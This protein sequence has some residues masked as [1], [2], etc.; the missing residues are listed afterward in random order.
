LSPGGKFPR[1][2]IAV[3]AVL[4][5]LLIADLLTVQIAKKSLLVANSLDFAMVLWA[6]CC[7]FYVAQRSTGY[8]RQ[9]WTLLGI[10]LALETLAQ[11]ISTYYQSFVPGS[12]HALWP[13]DVL[14][15][16]WVAPVFMMF[17]PPP[18]GKGEGVDWL[19]ALDFAQI[20]IVAGTAYLYFFYVPSRWQTN[21]ASL[22][23]QILIL[24]IARDLILSAG[25]LLRS[26]TSLSPW[27]KLFSLGMAAVF[28]AAGA[29]DGDYLFTLGLT[30][31]RA[32]WGDALWMVPYFLVIVLAA[33]WKQS[34][35]VTRPASTAR[36][37]DYVVTQ[38]L[39]VVIP[40][41]VIFM[42]RAIAREQFLVAW[43]AITAS[44]LCS[45]LRL[46]LTNEKQRQIS[47]ELLETEHALRASERILA[48]AF[49][50]SPDGYSITVFPGGP[51]LD[52]N[53][54]F[55]RLTGY[56][57]GEVINKTPQD[58]SLWL[59]PL[60]RAEVLAQLIEK[61]EIREEEFEFRTKNGR[62]RTGQM[63][64]TLVDLD[65]RR[66]A[67]VAVR[68]V[69]ERKEAESLLRASEERFRSLVENLHVGIVSYDSSARIQF[70]NQAIEEMVGMPRE[71]LIGKTSQELGLIPVCEDGTLIPAALGPVSQVIATKQPIRSL[72][73]GWKIPTSPEIL[74]TLLDAIP[75]F[76]PDG[77]LDRVIA[78][79]TNLTEQRRAIEALRESEE[80]FR[81]LVRDLQ[82][83]VV[84]HGTDSRIQFANRAALDMFGFSEEEV[85][86]KTPWEL[87][88]RPVDEKGRELAEFELPASAVLHTRAPVRRTIMGFRRR[89][90]LEPLWI[91]GNAAPQLDANGNML[92]VIT[93]FA[94]ITEMKIAERA[95]HQLSTQ[96]VKLQDEERRRIGRELHD[97]LAQTVLAINLSLAQTR[98]SI[99]P[100]NEAAVRSLERARGLL[101]QMSREIRT[102]SYLLHP[103]L[104]D[105]LGLVS[106]LKEYAKGFGERSGIATEFAVS[107]E[108]PRLSQAAEI[109]LF[110]IA[111]E[112]LANVQRHSGSPTA[113]ILLSQQAASVV[114]EVKDSGRGMP[115]PSN[116]NPRPEQARLGVG[117]PGM[118]ERLAQLGGR[119][120]IDSG[121][122]GTT[123][124]ATIPV[125]QEVSRKGGD[126]SA[127]HPYRG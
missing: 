71:A 116:G 17:L 114:L 93:S 27:L 68:D 5:A 66:C 72:L 50:S 75:E 25:F 42:G 81:T 31:G 24:Y 14:F 117:I 48:S 97:G 45:A 39:P 121:T 104:L 22:L 52:V 115:V 120:E 95:I 63:S 87:G 1:I 8:A 69:T 102:L 10:A 78:S 60:R 34:E 33:I 103:P 89:N 6:S 28:F 98:Q 127:S 77:K 79:A 4:A 82:V 30:A 107:S 62:I 108:F 96:L 53:E 112:S 90:S 2:A 57:R 126:A 49:R 51:Y 15:F 65:D 110:R 37:G 99:E 58:L 94:D 23:R 100:R 38:I 80:R 47:K 7:S 123:I 21:E 70:A 84:L 86:G 92:R 83:G 74:W 109:A 101:Q 125:T 91:H 124:R 40:L 85:L 64:A 36:R 67:L 44:V 73:I 106:T 105:D 35:P 16:L 29:S 54:S 56:T 76:T 55:T 61:G 119:L 118:R 19:R 32:S 12:A 9:I 26:R 46:I 41:S 3:A 13:S 18:E 122:Q 11:A 43:V 88:L 111:Q 59:N 20:T 113:R